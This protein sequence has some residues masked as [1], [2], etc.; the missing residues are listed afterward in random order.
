MIVT[1]CQSELKRVER[2]EKIISKREVVYDDATYDKLAGLW[3]E[4]YNE[5]PSEDAY[6][7]W[8][9]AARYAKWK[10]YKSL[11][12][13]G[14]AKYPANPTLL[15]LK[16]L[17][18]DDGIDNLE[19]IR[20]YEKAVELDPTFLDPWFGLAIDYMSIGD[21]EKSDLALRNLLEEKAISDEVMDY[22]YNVISLLEKNAILITN[23]DNDTYPAWI[24]TKIIKY[25]PD[26]R[27]I[28]RS[29][30]NTDWYPIHLINNENIPEFI[31]ERSLTSLRDS[32]LEDIKSEKTNMPAVGPFSDALLSEIIKN[33]EKKNRPLYFAATLYKTGIIRELKN[34][35]MDFGLIT[36]IDK[37]EQ[38]YSDQIKASIK[39]WVNKF[40]T[41]GLESWK[42]KYGKS[43]DAGKF[44]TLNYGASIELLIEPVKKYAPEYLLPLFNWY[45]DYILELLSE[46]SAANI[47]EAWCQIGN[48]KEIRDWCNKR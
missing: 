20:L 16:A 30:L 4:Y 14:I 27:I 12:S 32:I 6:A 35:G 47:N 21:L 2:P 18:K 3:Q 5:F 48:I 31:D 13:E 34:E 8:M 22:N 42:L 43:N 41:G 37:S 15:Y 11:L 10:E 28:N 24:I 26:V 9:Y 23:G 46:K 39:T 7:N 29:L 36:R 38:K 40:R 44:F 19:S 1:S 45:K 33:A 25:R 17:V